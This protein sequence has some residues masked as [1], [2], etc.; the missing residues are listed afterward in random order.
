MNYFGIDISKYKHDCFI[1][2]DLGEVINEGF[3]FDNSAEGFAVLQ[4]ELQNCK[5]GGVRI[6]FEATGNYAV[7][8]KNFL[9]KSGFDYMEINPFLI[10]EFI[11]SKS[12]RKTK[13]DKLDA[14][15]FSTLSITRSYRQHEFSVV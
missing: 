6:G 13:T 15:Y 1:I 5:H 11:K 4:L 14:K 9:E 7:N 10:K 2:T 3:S 8:L 12:L